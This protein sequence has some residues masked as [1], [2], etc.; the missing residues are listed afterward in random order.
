MDLSRLRQGFGE[1]MPAHKSLSN[2]FRMHQKLNDS[3]K[4]GS[5]DHKWYQKPARIEHCSIR[6]GGRPQR[7]VQMPRRAR[8]L[9]IYGLDLPAGRQE[10]RNLKSAS[11]V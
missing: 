4:D 5:S 1:A 10:G 7:K 11:A 9:E 6:S 8:C 3:N 2:T